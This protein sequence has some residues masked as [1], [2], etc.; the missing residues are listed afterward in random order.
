MESTYP[1]NEWS[2]GWTIPHWH[3]IVEDDTANDNL[4]L[5]VVPQ[6]GRNLD[7]TG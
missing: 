2:E 6:Y 5:L 4:D 3:S 7:H 1:G